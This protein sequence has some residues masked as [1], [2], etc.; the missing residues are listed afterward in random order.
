MKNVRMFEGANVRIFK[1]ANILLIYPLAVAKPSIS[2]FILPNTLS[3][4]PMKSC[5]N[6]AS[7]HWIE[8]HVFILAI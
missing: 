7:V 4:Y 8:K 1:Y 2:W 5:T 6:L 3:I